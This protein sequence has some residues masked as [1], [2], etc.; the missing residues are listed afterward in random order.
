VSFHL[1]PNLI[2]SCSPA[3][4]LPSSS[5]FH[6]FPHILSVRFHIFCSYISNSPI[7]TSPPYPPSTSFPL[8]VL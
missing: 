4:L 1:L 3:S 8:S 7:P 6:F 2:I 5:D